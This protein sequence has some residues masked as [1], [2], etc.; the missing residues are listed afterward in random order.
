MC[1]ARIR[2]P[3]PPENFDQLLQ[4]A[5]EV[6][7]LPIARITVWENDRIELRAQYGLRDDNF[8]TGWDHAIQGDELLEVPD[9]TRDERF[10]GAPEVTGPSHIRFYAGVPLISPARKRLGTLA[11]MDTAPRM[12]HAG[13]RQRMHV[14]AHQVMVHFELRRQGIEL[15]KL[16]TR[17]NQA[18]AELREQ[19]DH[20]K[21]AQHIAAVGSWKYL[22][23]EDVLR[24]SDEI[25]YMFGIRSEDFGGSLPAFL[26]LVHPEDRP[27]VNVA[28]DMAVREGH[29]SVRCRVIRPSGE[30]RHFE[31]IARLFTDENARPYLAGTTQDITERKASE[32]KIHQLAY[33]DTLTGLPNRRHVLDR[34]DHLVAMRQ[35]ITH[36][37]ALLFIDLDNFKTLNDT[38]GHDKGDLMLKAVAERLQSCVRHYDCV[39]R[40]GG[41]EFVVLLENIGDSPQDCATHAMHVARK[42]VGALNKPYDL[43]GLPYRSTPSIGIAIIDGEATSTGELLKRAD[44]AMYRAKSE[45]RNAIRFFSPSMQQLFNARAA[46]E[47][48]LREALATGGFCL[49]YQPQVD[50]DGSIVGAE[51]LLRWEHPRRGLVYPAEFVPL[52]EEAGLIMDIGRWL[53]EESC[54]QLVNW[55]AHPFTAS[56]ALSVNV[57]VRQFRHPGFVSQVKDIIAATGA[58]AGKLKIEITESLLIQDL[59]DTKRK[60]L[61]LKAMGLRFSLDDFGTGYSSLAYLQRLPL[62]QLKIDQS[63]VQD[64]ATNQNDAAIT[65]AIISLGHNLGLSV[66]AEGVETMDQQVFLVR[67]GCQNFQGYLHHRPLSATMF[68]AFARSRGH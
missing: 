9:T 12:L 61:E 6:C 8:S 60:M 17:L 23:G 25:L 5:A 1:P 32:D 11:F 21:Q 37:G 67:E 58:D 26:D 59:E 47:S 66:I 22:I 56:L 19:A 18:N 68:D 48:E 63:F 40:F 53:L 54:R 36:D 43:G 3:A 64:V 49:H 39:G 13:Q 31:I 65:R 46:M 55:S 57:S 14:V 51:A 2:Q 33:Y 50:L 30:T 24:L 44:M 34:I 27:A 38:H 20:L 28:K 35:R 16:A 7:D 41:D 45:G 62:D 15:E 29:A 4:L 52:A 10:A 42:I